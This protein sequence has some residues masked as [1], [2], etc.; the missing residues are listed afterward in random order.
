[1]ALDERGALDVIAVR[2]LETT[3]GQRTLWTDADRAW[4]SRAAAEVVGEGGTPEAFLTQ[5]ARLALGRA[6]ERF[7]ALPRAVR[8][9]RWR[10]WVGTAI[11]AAAFVAGVAIDRI[12]DAQRINVLAPPV[13][14]LLRGISPC[15]A[16]SRS[17]SSCTTATPWRR[18]RCGARWRDSPA[19]C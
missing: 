2:A 7:K 3:D 11:V 10:P 19:G 18:D 12:G 8:S 5:R 6:G 4:A 15:T 14:A 17:G 16:C 9:L 1:M 13:L